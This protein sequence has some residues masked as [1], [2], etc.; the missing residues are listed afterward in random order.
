MNILFFIIA[1]LI[2]GSF[3]NVLIFR[4]P[5]ME[6]VIKGRSHCP[7]CKKQ[8][9]WYDLIPLLSFVALAGRCRSCKETISYVYPLVETITAVLFAII[10]LQFG[11][12]IFTFYLI[13]VSCILIVIFFYD[14]KKQLIPDEMIIAG[15]VI[16]IIYYLLSYKAY[17]LDTVL[18]GF[19]IGTLFIGLIV[20]FTKGKGMGI[21]DIKL[22]ALLGLVI[23]YPKIIPLL[24]FAFVIGSL[25]GLFLIAS[26]KKG[27]KDPIAFAPFLI[28]SF[29]IVLFLGDQ[30]I[31]WYLKI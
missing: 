8:I 15:F 16:S 11:L 26:H 5:D 29:Y 4:L 1:G 18:L 3:L 19:L 24:F 20:A 6:S 13:T 9:P 31:N 12:T 21:G 25:Y 2:V 30:I 14:A 17:H 27:L 23:G 10:Y 28:L 22:A 7:K